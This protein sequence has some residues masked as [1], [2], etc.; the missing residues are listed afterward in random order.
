MTQ[1]DPANATDT[2]GRFLSFRHPG[3]SPDETGLTK[4]SVSPNLTM[5]ESSPYILT[6]TPPSFQR[7]I[8]SNYSYG[9]EGDEEQLKKNDRD[10][11]KVGR[12]QARC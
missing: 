2:H 11:T 10:H 6:H 5:D 4:H 9:F 3:T 12:G 8:Q 1:D 7:M